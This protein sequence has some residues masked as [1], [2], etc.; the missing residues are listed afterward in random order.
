MNLYY[1]LTNYHLL[2]SILHKLIYLPNEEAIFVTSDGRLKS[3]IESLK[4]SNI[5]K[6]VYYIEDKKLRDEKLNIALSQYDEKTNINEIED[7]SNEFVKSYDKMIQFDIKKIDNFYICADH[8][9]F[10]LYLLIKK[11]KY[12]YLEDARGIYSNWEKLDKALKA[13]D[14]GMR[15]MSLYYKAYG[16]S[17]LIIKKYIA[18]NSQSEECD[19]ENCIDFDINFLIDKLNPEQLNKIFEIF[20][21]KKYEVK[22]NKKNTLILTQRFSTYNLLS[23]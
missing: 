14:A 17:D 22:N 9:A 8:G 16:K 11:Q 10:G 19:F 20:K 2:C 3:R 5:F 1:G 7:I 18:F 21:L 4:E 23:R 6:E 12:I 15:L 13:K